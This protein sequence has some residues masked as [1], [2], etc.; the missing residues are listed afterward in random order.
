M[1]QLQAEVVH[2]PGREEFGVWGVWIAEE[3]QVWAVAVSG[4]WVGP[5]TVPWC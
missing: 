4:P 1:I 5:V 2:L 3:I